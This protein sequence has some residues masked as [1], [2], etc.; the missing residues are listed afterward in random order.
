MLGISVQLS[1]RLVML[2]WVTWGGASAFAKEAS[3]NDFIMFLHAFCGEDDWTCSGKF[4]SKSCRLLFPRYLEAQLWGSTKSSCLDGDQLGFVRKSPS[5]YSTLS[6][7]WSVGSFQLQSA[8]TPRPKPTNSNASDYLDI[9]Q[10]NRSNL[11]IGPGIIFWPLD[12]PFPDP[13]WRQ[14]V[15]FAGQLEF[16]CHWTPCRPWPNAAKWLGNSLGAFDSAEDISVI[17]LWLWMPHQ[18]GKA[19]KS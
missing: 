19:G 1:R 5:L 17:S 3:N 9:G 12:F 16:G 10:F 15:L 14:R 13:S 8:S 11:S 2:I 18:H 7:S 4:N 6:G